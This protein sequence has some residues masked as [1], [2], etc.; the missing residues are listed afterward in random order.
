[1]N[2]VKILLGTHLD[3]ED[4]RVVTP[5]EGGSLAQLHEFSFHELSAHN[6]TYV[7]YI[8]DQLTTELVTSPP[9]KHAEPDLKKLK[10]WTPGKTNHT[11][12]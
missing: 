6:D 5:F 4:Q 12:C 9:K 3:E 7:T 11:C 1:M 8:L 2:P 10:V